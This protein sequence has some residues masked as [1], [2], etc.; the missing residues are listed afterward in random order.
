MAAECREQEKSWIQVSLSVEE[1]DAVTLVE[2]AKMSSLN[3]LDLPLAIWRKIFEYLDRESRV[4][5]SASCK[6]L[7]NFFR[8]ESQ[9]SGHVHLGGSM[10]PLSGFF[11]LDDDDED[12]VIDLGL[13]IFDGKERWQFDPVKLN[14]ILDKFPALEKLTIDIKRKPSHNSTLLQLPS[15]VNFKRHANLKKVVISSSKPFKFS[16]N[17]PKMLEVSHL[18]FDPKKDTSLSLANGIT[19]ELNIDTSLIPKRGYAR[20]TTFIRS[21]FL[22]PVI[23]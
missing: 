9:F 6:I 14:A 21:R 16:E 20:G 18:S 17:V 11:G 4:E 2:L 22:P 7:C 19:N 10:L 3:L 13:N 1:W 23:Y 12:L 8:N 5:A 15:M